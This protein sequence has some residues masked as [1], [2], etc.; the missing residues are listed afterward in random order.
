M[1]KKACINLLKLPHPCLYQPSNDGPTS[2]NTQQKRADFVW[3]GA[4]EGRGGGFNLGS[5]TSVGEAESSLLWQKC[6]APPA[7]FSPLSTLSKLLEPPPLMMPGNHPAPKNQTHPVKPF[8]IWISDHLLL[9][10]D[11]Y[12]TS[13]QTSRFSILLHRVKQAGLTSAA[14]F[15]E[16]FSGIFFSPCVTFTVFL[17]EV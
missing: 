17:T 8:E 1:K 16:A 4:H 9:H 2:T 10:S 14:M 13:P 5:V 15:T 7:W 11:G 12:L 6:C 3:G